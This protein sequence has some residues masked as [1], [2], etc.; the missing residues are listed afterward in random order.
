MAATHFSGPAAAL[1]PDGAATAAA[2]VRTGASVGLSLGDD[3]MTVD[4]APPSPVISHREC[5][6]CLSENYVDKVTLPC[7]HSICGPCLAAWVVAAPSDTASCPS[8]RLQIAADHP[9]VRA[10]AAE[11]A[12]TAAFAR[13]AAATAAAAGQRHDERDRAM[14]V[15]CV[16]FLFLFAAAG[17]AAVE[18]RH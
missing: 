18:A 10:A 8:C 4:I 12:A 6:V 7:R 9:A 5:P 2:V 17:V 13:A 3:F 1:A 14:C 16:G 15:V 11:R